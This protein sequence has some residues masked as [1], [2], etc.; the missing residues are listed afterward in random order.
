MSGSGDGMAAYVAASMHVQPDT[1]IELSDLGPM[2]VASYH[3]LKLG[4]TLEGLSIFATREGLSRLGSAILEY[5]SSPPLEHDAAPDGR[6]AS[7]CPNC[8]SCAVR[9]G[10]TLRVCDACSTHWYEQ[11]ALLPEPMRSEIREG[12]KWEDA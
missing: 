3:C 6:E 10:D 4:A 12:I 11:G 1:E 8:G 9:V 5:L 7:R 2:G